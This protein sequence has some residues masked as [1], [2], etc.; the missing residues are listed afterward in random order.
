ML[1]SKCYLMFFPFLLGITLIIASQ[2]VGA[3]QMVL[4]ETFLKGRGY[5]PFHVSLSILNFLVFKLFIKI[6]KLN[7]DSQNERSQKS[8]IYNTF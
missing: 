8:F 1:H 4:E 7:K 2:I 3:I 5:E 6:F